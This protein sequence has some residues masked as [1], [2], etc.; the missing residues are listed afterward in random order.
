MKKFLTLLS[1][2]LVL[3]AVS[4]KKNSDNGGETTDPDSGKEVT[5]WANNGA[6]PQ[7]DIDGATDEQASYIYTFYTEDLITEWG[8]SNDYLGALCIA[9]YSWTEGEGDFE[10]NY[11]R[12]FDLTDYTSAWFTFDWAREKYGPEDMDTIQAKGSAGDFTTLTVPVACPVNNGESETVATL[13]NCGKIDLSAYCGGRVT[14]R[15]HSYATDGNAGTS[16]F[17][18]FELR[19]VKK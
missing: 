18:N 8:L 5:I 11:S 12:S 13:I 6:N 7:W 17:K 16:Y 3:T 1:I 14:L 9:I 15:I 2:G 4:C 19:G 10:C